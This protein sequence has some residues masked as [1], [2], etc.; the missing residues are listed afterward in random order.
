MEKYKIILLLSIIIIYIYFNSNDVTYIEYFDAPNNIKKKYLVRDVPDKDVA[1]KVLFNI[2]TQLKKLV[3]LLMVDENVKKN[4]EMYDYIKTINEKLQ[5][6]EI[7]ESS[8]DSQYTSYSVNKGELLVFC[9]RSKKNFKIHDF[10]DLLYVAIHEIAHIGCTEV[11]HTDLF[12]KINEYLIKKA[13]EY[14]IYKYVN[15]SLHHKEFCGMELTV[16]VADRST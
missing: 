5:S 1:V 4:T 8:A 12:F 6:V 9:I 16:S 13:I 3:S 2:E 10:N 15:Y 14:D 7:Q 11:G